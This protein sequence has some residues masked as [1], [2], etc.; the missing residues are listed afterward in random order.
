MAALLVYSLFWLALI[1][2][3]IS[4]GKSSVH[5]SL[6]FISLWLFISVL[7]PGLVYLYLQNQFA[8][9]Q[10]LQ[11]TLKQRMVMNSGWDKDQ[12]ATLDHFLQSHPQFKATKPLTGSGEWKWYY[13]QQ[14]LSDLAVDQQ[15][16]AYQQIEQLRLE[17]LNQLSYLSPSLLFQLHIN[18][19]AGSGSDNQLGYLQKVADYHQQIR[20][21]IYPYLFLE[22][23]FTA[24]DI[25]AFPVWPMDSAVI[26]PAYK[27][28][29]AWALL[30]S[31]LL[32]LV[33]WRLK[34]GLGVSLSTVRG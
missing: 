19:L 24:Q 20:R 1:G 28:L 18:R 16:Q 33:G 8:N 23:P 9:D 29:M 25:D 21:F 31:G 4:W 11:A 12:Q 17:K 15:W 6:S 14:H 26:K 22:Q 7:L 30:L 32:L 3:I 27:G 34:G 10:A 5:N 13:A 2:W